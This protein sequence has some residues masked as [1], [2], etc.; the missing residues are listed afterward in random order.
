MP[1]FRTSQN[2]LFHDTCNQNLDTLLPIFDSISSLKNLDDLLISKNIL[3]VIKLHPHAKFKK[4]NLRNIIYVTNQD[5]SINNCKLYNFI[6]NFDSLIT[7]Y[8][9]IFADYYLL[10]KPIAFTT[11]DMEDYK[12]NR[13]FA[14][15]N[16]NEILA[17]EL[18]KNENDFKK[19]IK[20]VDSESD[21]FKQERKSVNKI[22]NKYSDG[23]CERLVKLAGIELD[24]SDH[25]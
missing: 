9:S 24:S 6:K 17:G 10:N 5:L 25:I 3:L 14:V 1:T 22:I 20:N 18:I 23:N 16:I 11:D 7:D 19:F 8:S 15:T 2:N 12:N 21:D 4:I 13:G